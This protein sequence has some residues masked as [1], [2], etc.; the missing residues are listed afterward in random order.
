MFENGVEE[1]YMSRLKNAVCR[2]NSKVTLSAH[3]SVDEHSAVYAVLSG[4]E[5][6][7]IISQLA[8]NVRNR[9]IVSES[10][11]LFKQ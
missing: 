4:S 1:W 9:S 6:V 8:S 2:W 10:K 5:R 3:A 11:T 7:G